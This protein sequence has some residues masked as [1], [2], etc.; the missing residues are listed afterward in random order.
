MENS[1][2]DLVIIGGGPTGLFGAFYAGMRQMSVVMID[3]LDRLGG[4]LA[5]LYPEKYIYDAP[6]YPR[7]LAKD[8]ARALELQALQYRPG[9][10][11]REHVAELDFDEQTRIYRVHTNRAVYRTRAILIAAGVGAF[12]PRKLPLAEEERFAGRGL[13]YFVR[14]VEEFRDKRVMIV[15]GGDSAIDWA[16]TLSPIASQVYLVHRRDQFRA[17][18]ESVYRMRQGRTRLRLFYELKALHGEG[19]VERVAIYDNRSRQ[20]EMLDVDAVLVNIGFESSLGPIKNWGLKLEGNAIRVDPQMR[21]NRPG[22][23]AAGDVCTYPGKLKLIATG[24][25]EAAIAVNYLKAYLDPGAKA[26]PGHS[27]DLR[28]ANR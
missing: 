2:V 27:T 1:V 19:W 20:E 15:G 23:A 21:T 25:G 8:L 5:T 17:H 7:V 9:V 24:Y 14:R 28:P 18:E 22:I 11:L 16:N 13:H 12:V 6:G 10:A 4:Q 3:S 26:F